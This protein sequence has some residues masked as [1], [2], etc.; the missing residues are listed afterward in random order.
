MNFA[1]LAVRHVLQGVEIRVLRRNFN[2]AT[3]TSR[4][5]KIVAVRIGHVGAIDVDSV[6]VKA[7]VQG[8]RVAGPRAVLAFRERAAVPKTHSDALSFRRNDAEFDAA[9]RV[10]L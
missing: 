3:P 9:L 6:V 1:E 5:K 8:P 2:G 4:A 10:N 7:F